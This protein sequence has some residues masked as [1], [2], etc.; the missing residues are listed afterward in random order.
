MSIKKVGDK[1]LYSMTGIVNEFLNSS[2]KGDVYKFITLLLKCDIINKKP[3]LY[4]ERT[5]YVYSPSVWFDV[6]YEGHFFTEPKKYK[7]E[8]INGT[9]YF[10]EYMAQVLSRLFRYSDTYSITVLKS[11]MIDRVALDTALEYIPK[12]SQVQKEIDIN[13]KQKQ[14]TIKD[15]Q[16]EE[17]VKQPAKGKKKTKK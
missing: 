12:I 6:M 13:K 9:L 16:K 11:K 14:M 8:M 3:L 4:G 2:Y 10:D 1:N 7:G 17:I 5:H 15:I